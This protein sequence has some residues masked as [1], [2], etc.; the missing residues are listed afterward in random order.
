MKDKLLGIYGLGVIVFTWTAMSG[1]PSYP[2]VGFF[3][4]VW[5]ALIWPIAVA[6]RFLG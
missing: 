5:P 1:S 3:E 4:A 2:A 6:M